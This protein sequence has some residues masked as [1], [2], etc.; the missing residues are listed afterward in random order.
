MKLF[1]TT[2]ATLSAGLIATSSL[3]AP[4]DI[5][6][7]L[8]GSGSM[9]GQIDGEA[10]ISTAKSTLTQLMDDVPTQARVGLMTYGT[11]SKESC[12]DVQVLNALGTDRTA[13]KASISGI[14]PL[15]KTPIQTALMQG[16]TM[17]SGAEPPA[18]K[19]SNI[20]LRD[21]RLNKHGLK[22]NSCGAKQCL[23]DVKRLKVDGHFCAGSM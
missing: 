2:L 8:D 11:T 20:L 13:I 12:T 5:L 3:A 15:G 4:T 23:F 21:L 10:K 19:R 7:I 18:S 22:R 14:T 9:W 6:F 17:L 16:I 1:E